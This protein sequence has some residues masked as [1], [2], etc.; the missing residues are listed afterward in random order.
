MALSKGNVE[1]AIGRLRRAIE[2]LAAAERRIAEIRKRMT[3]EGA[4]PELEATFREMVAEA[5]ESHREFG[6]AMT[7]VIAMMDMVDGAVMGNRM[8]TGLLRSLRLVGGHGERE[9][10]GAMGRLEAEFGRL[11]AW[12]G[13]LRAIVGSSNS[14]PW[15]GSC[16]GS[17]DCGSPL[18]D[19]WGDGGHKGQEAAQSEVAGSYF[20]A[21][22]SPGT[23]LLEDPSGA[24]SV[25]LQVVDIADTHGGAPISV[26]FGG[27]GG[28]LGGGAS[29][30]AS[31][32]E[33]ASGEGYG[34]I[35]GAMGRTP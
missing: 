13:D 26:D 19:S 25:S 16:S 1:A 15:G 29:D 31:G 6:D 8:D 4:S 12:K 10:T 11:V 7:L 33:A 20:D 35:G 34:A 2:R 28:S 3:K 24:G 17:G 22:P 5:E 21:G 32:P 18:F 27:N 23:V 9:V 14:E 30:G